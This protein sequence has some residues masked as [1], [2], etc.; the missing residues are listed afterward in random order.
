MRN[1]Q[2]GKNVSTSMCSLTSLS[3]VSLCIYRLQQIKEAIP[4]LRSSRGSVIFV[5]SGAA[6]N[7]YSG[8][9]A[10][11]ASKAAINSIAQSLALEE[12][13]I[14]SLAIRP[15]VV[16]TEMQNDIRMKR[17]VPFTAAQVNRR[18]PCNGSSSRQIRSI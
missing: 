17:K 13:T 14:T 16:D 9:S 4:Y 10:Y 1:H 8:W 12:P 3:Y 2:D 15:G 5:S 7:A 6:T 11:S 18:R